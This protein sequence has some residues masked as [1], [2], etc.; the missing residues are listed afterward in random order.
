MSSRFADD[1]RRHF[2]EG[3]SADD[4][5]KKIEKEKADKIDSNTKYRKIVEE[6]N[7]SEAEKPRT[8]EQLYELLIHSNPEGVKA[9][10]SNSDAIVMCNAAFGTSICEILKLGTFI[11]Y[12]GMCGKEVTILLM[13]NEKRQGGKTGKKKPW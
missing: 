1:F 11:K 12:A 6:M 4:I 8:K 9:C 3:D 10:E 13:E 5:L 2:S 7:N